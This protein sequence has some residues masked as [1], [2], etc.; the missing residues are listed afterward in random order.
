VLLVYD[1]AAGRL[2]REQVFEARDDA[3]RARF[4]A[5]KQYRGL[6]AQVEVVVLGARSRDALL[7]THGRYFLSLDEL[8]EALDAARVEPGELAEALDATRTAGPSSR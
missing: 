8:A 3:L 4:V 7:Q 6:E 2:L 5:E 1:R